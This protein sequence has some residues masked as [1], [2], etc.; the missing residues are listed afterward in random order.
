MDMDFMIKYF[1]KSSLFFQLNITLLIIILIF[2]L[3]SLNDAIKHNKFRSKV[4]KKISEIKLIL[5]SHSAY[6][7]KNDPGNFI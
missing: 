2:T 7:H 1:L 5:N 6:I 3:F 4:Y